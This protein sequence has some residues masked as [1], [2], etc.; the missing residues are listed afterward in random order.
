MIPEPAD[1]RN[2]HL[3]RGS[4]WVMAGILV[5]A[6]TGI[7]FWFLA[8]SFETARTI[9]LASAIFASIQFI[10][11][12]TTLGLPEVIAAFPGSNKQ[13]ADT[14]LTRAVVATIL[15]TAVGAA[16]FLA[17]AWSPGVSNVLGNQVVVAWAIVAIL[18]GGNA[19]AQLLDIHFM[20]HHRWGV[21]FSRNAVV[22]LARIPLLFLLD[23]DHASLGVLLAMS[24]PIALSG[25][26]GL[27]VAAKVSGFVPR[28]RGHLSGSLLML[29]YSAVQYMSH[30]ALF[31]PQFVLPVLVLADVNPEVN[32]NFFLAW[33]ITTVVSIVPV[34]VGRVLVV[35]GSRTAGINRQIR[36]GLVFAVS[37]MV[38][39][40]IL[41]FPISRVMIEVYGE[42]FTLAADLLPRLVLGCLPW[43]VIAIALSA[44]RVRHDHVG[45]VLVTTA[46]AVSLVVLGLA[47]VSRD[48]AVGAA[49]AWL[50]SNTFS[51]LIA[52]AV[53]HRNLRSDRGIASGS[54]SATAMAN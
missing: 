54:H 29:R 39:A 18:G 9:G 43:A 25:Y 26:V 46:L 33:T 8:A 38:V 4:S 30:L 15:A 47:L 7:L 19:V 14:L 2:R 27:G 20:A 45:S 42:E 12:A 51:S 10:N 22:G 24:G 40:V 53:L 13:Q 23:L 48:G 6:L 36:T 50:L 34:I 32:A 37:L 35:E 28:L 16:V 3:I 52:V 1:L 11:Y 21:V 17:A 5:Q 41:A 49:N 31:A 44:A